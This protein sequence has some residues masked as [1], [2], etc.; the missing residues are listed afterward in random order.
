VAYVA[1][2]DSPFFALPDA[3]GK[4]T[5]KGVPEGPGTLEVWHE[6]AEPLAIE[7]RVPA[8]AGLMARLEITKPRLP[9][10]LNKLGKSYNRDRGDAYQ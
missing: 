8:P 3:N 6:Q 1:V 2:L 9:A 10:H 5:L 4:F 7:T